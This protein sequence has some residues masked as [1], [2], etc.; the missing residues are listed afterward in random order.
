MRAHR[1]LILFAILT[2][3]AAA[4]PARAADGT[5]PSPNGRAA[6]SRPHGRGLDARIQDL[7]DQLHVTDAQAD[8]WKAV[9]DV[10]R[11][12][13]D[14]MRKLLREQRANADTLTAV[15]TLDAYRQVSDLRAEH[16]QK[17][18]AAFGALY[19]GMSPEQKKIADALFRDR[20]RQIGQWSR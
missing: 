4:A 16:V 19:S 15:E 17:L 7:H 20:K 14:A 9:A 3:I 5:P 11:R 18:A 2:S 8:A 10:M 6:A 13:D 1:I 12:N